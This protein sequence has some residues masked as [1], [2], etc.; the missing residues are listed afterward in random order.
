M[1][2]EYKVDY[3]DKRFTDVN[4]EKDEA[5]KE[6]DKTYNDMISE[7][8]GYYQKQID[9]LDEYGDKQA[10]NQQ[11]MTDQA[12][13][14]IE[15]KKDK[16]HGD[17]L[18]EQSGAYTDWQKQSNQYGVNAERQA[19]VGMG[20]SGYSES[21]Q[22]AMYNQYQ[23][24]VASARESYVTAVQ[25][26]D[27]AITNARLQNNSL[28]AEI[29]YNTLKTKLE[30][31][32]Q[33][34]QYKNTL[35][36]DKVR[37]KRDLE[38]TYYGRYQDVLAQINTENSMAEQIRQFNESMAFQREQLAEQQRQFDEQMAAS[39]G[40]S[41]SGG[42]GSYYSSDGSYYDDD[43]YDDY[44][45]GDLGD[46]G[47]DPPAEPTEVPSDAK[48]DI[49]HGPVSDGYV[50]NGIEDGS[51]TVDENTGIIYETPNTGDDF[52]KTMFGII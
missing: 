3:N 12:I 40:S 48:L 41:G 45:Y 8:D 23:N 10:A 31:S 47:G 5:I 33:G 6:S 50:R 46:E 16:L 21:S 11:A 25:E 14:E 49:G 51:L 32:L 43:Y 20:N 37:A 30:L 26:Y 35:L 9:A 4:A 38:N 42:G 34:F 29:A 13:D 18:D 36:L 19:A 22:V 2:D 44:Y 15:Q 1:A 17:Y 39:S 27:N 28:L 7:S 24:R 52:W